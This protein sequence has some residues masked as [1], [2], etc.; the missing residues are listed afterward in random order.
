[1]PGQ[2][3]S[4]AVRHVLLQRVRDFLSPNFEF[5]LRIFS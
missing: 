3:E 4:V 1:M 2:I 5:C